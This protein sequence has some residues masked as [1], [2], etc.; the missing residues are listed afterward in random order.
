[1]N[2]MVLRDS[3]LILCILVLFSSCKEESPTEPVTTAPGTT[4]SF[5]SP[6]DNGFVLENSVVEVRVV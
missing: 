3:F 4:V 6:K 1:M 2:I 5:I